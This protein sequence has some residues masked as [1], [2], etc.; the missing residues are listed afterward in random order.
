VNLESVTFE[1]GSAAIT[2]DQASQ[3]LALGRY[4]SNAIA[5]TRARSS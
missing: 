4:M 1:T 5:E 3:L 2:A